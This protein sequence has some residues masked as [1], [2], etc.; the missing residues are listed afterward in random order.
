LTSSGG[1]GQMGRR[2]AGRVVPGRGVS[3]PFRRSLLPSM[4]SSAPD[5]PVPSPRASDLPP[6]LVVDDEYGPREA[7]AFSLS[8]VLHVL[9]WPARR[10]G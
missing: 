5:S 1:G 10:V 4:P 7:I 3:L 2:L 8:A 6:V 9:L